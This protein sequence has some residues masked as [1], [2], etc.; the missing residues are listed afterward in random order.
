MKNHCELLGL[1]LELVG[2][3]HDMSCNMSDWM[4]CRV[5]G[6]DLCAYGTTCLFVV[7]GFWFFLWEMLKY[8]RLESYR[9]PGVAVEM[10]SVK[11]TENVCKLAFS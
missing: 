4:A 1:R 3:A 5:D 11:G 7:V 2:G 8:M 10:F 6:F 9:L